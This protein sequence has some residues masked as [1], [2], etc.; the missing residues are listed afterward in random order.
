[1]TVEDRVVRN[2]PEVEKLWKKWIFY[3]PTN[4][5][6]FKK[7]QMWVHETWNKLNEET[8]WQT[9]NTSGG[10]IV[11]DQTIDTNR[12]GARQYINV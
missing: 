8:C 6:I 10:Y 9:Q 1:M 3:S 11:A 2:E 5:I 7:Q 12:G 4:V